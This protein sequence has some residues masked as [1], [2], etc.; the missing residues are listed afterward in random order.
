MAASTTRERTFFYF[1]PQRYHDK[2]MVLMVIIMMYNT[3]IYGVEK[4][5]TKKWTRFIIAVKIFGK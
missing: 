2:S 4:M 5:Y 1:I 3:V